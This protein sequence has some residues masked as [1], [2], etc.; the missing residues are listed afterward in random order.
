[1]KRSIARF[2][3]MA[4]LGT[5]VV[6]MLAPEAMA[7][8][9]R[10]GHPAHR[11][12]RVHG[13]RHGGAVHRPAVRRYPR[14]RRP[15]VY[16]HRGTYGSYRRPR[17]YG[18]RFYLRPLV[19]PVYIGAPVVYVPAPPVVVPVR[20]VVVHEA[21]PVEPE[22]IIEEHH[23]F[24]EVVPRD[25]EDDYEY[26][27]E[28]EP[29][30]EMSPPPVD[31]SGTIEPLSD[32]ELYAI[33]ERILHLVAQARREAGLET[34]THQQHMGLA[35]VQHSGEMYSMDYFSHTS[36]VE[37]NRAFTDRL[38]AAGV[39]QFGSASENI[40]MTGYGKD[41]A[42]DLFRMWMES[43]P[44]RANILRPE[45][46]YT[47]IGVYGDKDVVYATQVFSSEVEVSAD[48]PTSL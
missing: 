40:A 18:P 22:V 10:R 8:R 27:E 13:A 31:E 4:L 46:Q 17:A 6:G 41:V 24:D 32:D 35:A 7:R 16:R 15:G 42:Q 14:Q 37:A 25:L 28:I 5:A 19:R 36:P 20:R 47:G 45:F 9:G 21:P 1:M 3:V 29:G 12:A 26:E 38:R 11:S 44:H 30:V 48:A 33:E 34:L 2:F 23:H 43:E 39:T